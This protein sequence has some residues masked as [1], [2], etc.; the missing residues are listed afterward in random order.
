MIFTAVFGLYALQRFSYGPQ[1]VGV[2]LMVLGLASALSQAGLAGPLTRRWGEQA[3]VPASF[4]ASCAGFM[5]MLL[6]NTYLT[7]LIA[8]GLF[9][10]TSALQIPA[11]TSLTSKRTT[12]PQG[13][14]MGISNSFISLGRIFGPL[15]AGA[16]FDLNPMLAYLGGAATM[17]AGFFVCLLALGSLP[18]PTAIKDR[19]GVIGRRCCKPPSPRRG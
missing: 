14:T 2:A 4:L 10:L 3:V 11:L 7:I 16:S 18:R 1:E 13:A 6:A 8:T 17:L 15:F 9:G 5:L 12:A 19:R